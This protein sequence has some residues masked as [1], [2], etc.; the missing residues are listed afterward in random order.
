MRPSPGSLP[1]SEMLL[2][3]Q[4]NP[5][6]VNKAKKTPS[7]TWLRVWTAQGAG[8]AALGVL[9]S[10]VR[11]LRGG[12]TQVPVATGG[13]AVI[14]QPLMRGPA[15]WG[16]QDPCDPNYSPHPCTWLPRPQRGHQVPTG[17]P[18]FLLFLW[19]YNALNALPH[20]PLHRCSDRLQPQRSASSFRTRCPPRQSLA[21]RLQAAPESR[22]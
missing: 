4:S 14:E 17:L 10:G 19:D 8:P 12:P 7:L 3:H 20:Y 2:Q 15:G 18:S 9:G 13:P 16:G 11:S 5:C 6:L 1:Q 21:S 22:D